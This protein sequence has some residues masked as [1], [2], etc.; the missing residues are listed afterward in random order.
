LL[1]NKAA[2]ILK[3]RGPVLKL[4]TGLSGLLGLPALPSMPQTNTKQDSAGARNT[5]SERKAKCGSRGLN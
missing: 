5:K 2:T 3:L 4:I 1:V